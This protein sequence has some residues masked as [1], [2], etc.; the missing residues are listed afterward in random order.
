MDPANHAAGTAACLAELSFI[1]TSAEDARLQD[2]EYLKALGEAVANGVREFVDPQDVQLQADQAA[3]A[4]GPTIATAGRPVAF[5]TPTV[6]TASTTVS[7]T[8][9]AIATVRPPLADVRQAIDV[10]P[11]RGRKAKYA[12]PVEPDGG[13]DQS[14]IQ[15]LAGYKDFFLIT[16]SDSN[17]QSGR[18]LVLDRVNEHKF[19]KEF[20]LPAFGTSGSSFFHA[21][22][23]QL[24]GDVLAVPSESGKNS[25]VIA[26]F[27]VSDPLNIKE[28]NGALCTLDFIARSCAAGHHQDQRNDDP[29]ESE[30]GSG[31]VHQRRGTV[32]PVVIAAAE[33][34]GS[35]L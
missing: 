29:L 21:G 27:D 5:R 20:P 16:H 28:F 32:H 14:H 3:A 30:Q 22:G 17:R 15:G 33:D 8:A 18:I 11:K 7:P 2:P 4:A 23:C 10:L 25:S 6:F 12:G 35:A 26:F 19:V 13:S 9:A 31:A 1:T 24:I 34:F